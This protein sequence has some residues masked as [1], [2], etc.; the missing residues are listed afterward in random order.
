M[1]PTEHKEPIDTELIAHIRESLIGHEEEYA[2]GAWE[3]FNGSQK[4]EKSVLGI[5]ILRSAAAVLIIGYISFLMMNGNALKEN[6][7]LSKTKNIN[8]KKAD[9]PNLPVKESKIK[10]DVKKESVVLNIGALIN[11]K[12]QAK[13]ATNDIKK[14]V[15]IKNEFDKGTNLELD[16]K[17]MIANTI[18]ESH[19]V[20]KHEP[21]PNMALQNDNSVAKI[22]TENVQIVTTA[23][24]LANETKKNLGKK[25]ED[26]AT[27]K[28]SKFT[29][30]LVVAPSFGNIKKLNMGYGLSVDYS[31]SNKISLN[32]GIAYNQL[33]AIKSNN[34]SSSAM[35]SPSSPTA[36]I[37]S[38]PTRSLTSVEQYVAGIDIPFELKY[39][40]NKNLYA[41][42]GVSA[43]ALT[44]QKTSNT[45]IENKV[46]QQVVYSADGTQQLSSF[47]ITDRVTEQTNESKGNNLSYLGFYNFSFGY[48]QKISKNNS[49]A[50]EPFM[51][52]PMKSVTTENLKLSSTGLKLKFDF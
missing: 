11:A 49:F 32:S 33:A 40:I 8:I 13:P 3:K 20:E 7:R 51:K 10:N 12:K 50:I 48:K 27:P 17:S 16:L 36:F 25:K 21:K 4:E 28:E 39:Y 45:Y 47:L 9:Q 6:Q 44:S 29:L 5:W 19:Q 1:K 31:L 46:V 43:F 14:E 37:S 42:V 2:P 30:G 18:N 35:N 38:A 52:L 26:L 41:N 24:F 15:I 23:D 34:S 22:K